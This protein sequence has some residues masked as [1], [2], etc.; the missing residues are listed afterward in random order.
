MKIIT[1]IITII[2]FMTNTAG[3]AQMQITSSAFEDNGFIPDKFSCKG[4]N[5][6]PDLNIEGIPEGTKSLALIMD[7]PDAPSGDWVH[8]VVY[9]I[10]VRGRIQENSIPGKQG[11]NDFGDTSYGGPCPPQGTHRYFFKVYALDKELALSEGLTKKEL[12]SAMAGHILAE[13][14]LIGLFRR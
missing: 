4:L 12:E 1:F 2:I 5:I 11:R 9:D 13:A 8:W 3:G 6:N 14:R 10:P 7:D